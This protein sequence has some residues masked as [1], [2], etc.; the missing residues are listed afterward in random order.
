MSVKGCVPLNKKDARSCRMPLLC[1]G[2]NTGRL[3][4]TKSSL[5]NKSILFAVWR[6]GWWLIGQ[7]I[8]VC[9]IA[10]PWTDREFGSQT[11]WMTEWLSNRPTKI[12]EGWL[13]DRLTIWLIYT[14]FD[15]VTGIDRPIYRLRLEW[16]NGSTESRIFWLTDRRMND[17]RTDWHILVNW[18]T[19]LILKAT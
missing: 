1:I 13:T 15:I 3:S 12:P 4:T 11:G 8:E 5:W 10:E 7:I 17:L 14:L 6:Y 9:L 2:C 19:I 18:I 16:V